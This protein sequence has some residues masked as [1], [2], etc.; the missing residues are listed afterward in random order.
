MDSIRKDAEVVL[1]QQEGERMITKEDFKAYLGVQWGGQTNMFDIGAVIAL[2][3]GVLDKK[4][5]LEIM[6]NY[7]ELYDKWVKE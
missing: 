6:E 4:A 3:G 5:C 2:S 1:Q 7:K